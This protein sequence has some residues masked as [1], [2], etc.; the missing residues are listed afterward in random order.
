MKLNEIIL[1]SCVDGGMKV[2]P[3]KSVKLILTDPPYG[4]SL[5]VGSRKNKIE[6]LQN[7]DNLDFLPEYFS[8]CNRILSDDGA[9]MCF[10][11]SRFNLIIEFGKQMEV[12]FG[13]LPQQIIWFNSNSGMGNLKAG[14]APCYENLLFYPKKDFAF[15]KHEKRPNAV[16][17]F[18]QKTKPEDYGHPTSKDIDM[19]R[20]LVRLSTEENDLVFDGFMG[21]G[22]TAAAAKMENR[23]YFGFEID[24]TYHSNSMKRLELTGV[25]SN[26]AALLKGAVK[27][28]TLEQELN[29]DLFD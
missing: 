17:V 20:Y 15:T 22:S 29:K 8:E 10:G 28:P 4:M 25:V 23:N 9:I 13:K 27:L 2:I 24:K 26:P 14:F 7:D 18:P 19:L 16:L 12:A 21:S 11:P 1:G 5:Q 6:T 3:D